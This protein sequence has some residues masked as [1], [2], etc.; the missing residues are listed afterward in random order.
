MA[1]EP[2]DAEGGAAADEGQIEQLV[3]SIDKT[4]GEIVKVE[5]L[6]PVSGDRV[7][8]DADDYAAIEAYF[9][10]LI[11]T[12]ATYMDYPKERPSAVE[13]AYAQGMM[14]YASYL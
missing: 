6:D 13:R 10:G 14:D 8:F 12:A 5:R 11:E 7:E 9:A 3:L 2:G 1:K 4:T